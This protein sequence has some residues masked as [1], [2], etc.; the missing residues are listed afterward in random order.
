LRL[1]LSTSAVA[2]YRLKSKQGRGVCK[3]E[4]EIRNKILF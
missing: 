1:V 4:V 2:Q 3:S